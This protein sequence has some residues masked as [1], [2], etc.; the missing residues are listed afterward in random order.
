VLGLHDRSNPKGFM[1]IK[2]IHSKQ[3]A[4]DGIIVRWYMKDRSYEV[5]S[6]LGKVF[7][8]GGFAEEVGASE[9]RKS[10]KHKGEDKALDPS[11]LRNKAS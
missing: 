7:V 2:M 4:D 8:D 1:R 6:D 9:K 5:G 3:G 10:S 11:T